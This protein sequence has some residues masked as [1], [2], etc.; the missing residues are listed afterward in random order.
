MVAEWSWMYTY[1]RE[2]REIISG[3]KI[4]SIK[5][6]RHFSKSKLLCI[7]LSRE[8]KVELKFKLGSSILAQRKWIQLGTMRFWVQS[9]ATISG[10]GS[11]VAVSCGVGGRR[12]WDLVLLWLW[13]RPAAIAPIRPLAWE[14]PYAM[15]VVL[16]RPPQKKILNWIGIFAV[17]QWDWRHLWSK[18]HPWPSTVG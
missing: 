7:F 6:I 14:P 9:L 10:L 1:W 5:N 11:S 4:L 15:G 16:K 17:V 13:H 12:S 18:L 8:F 3:W 2:L